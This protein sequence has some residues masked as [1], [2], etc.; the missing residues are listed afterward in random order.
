MHATIQKTIDEILDML[1]GED[2][3]FVV[4]CGNCA[5][6]CKSGGEPE[7]KEM[8]RRLEERG[9][10]VTGWAVSVGSLCVLSDT[11]K[12]LNSEHRAAV[13]MADSILV[14]ACGQGVH[15][16]IDATGKIVHPGCNTIFGGETLGIGDNITINEYCSLCG[17]CIAEFTGGLC[18][19][20]LCSKG[21]LNGPCGG[22]VDGKCEVDKERDCGW[23]LI[24]ERLK[25]IG[26]LDN[27]YEYQEPKDYSKWSR[28]RRLNLVNGRPIFKSVSGEYSPFDKDVGGCKTDETH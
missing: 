27:L 19:L 11:K 5:A 26:K 9:K 22:A 7:T 23:N 14:L 15:T 28:P 6:K 12:M 3:V 2:K 1:K 24:Y 4:G 18:P 17:E 21:L 8:C 16:V 10:T 20:T 13:E 25:Q